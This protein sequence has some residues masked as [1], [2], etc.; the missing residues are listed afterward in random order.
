MKLRKM[1]RDCGDMKSLNDFHV[2][3]VTPDG[4]HYYCKECQNERGAKW[5]AANPDKAKEVAKRSQRKRHLSSTYG[6]SVDEYD[7]LLEKQGGVCP[8][9]Q[10]ELKR[11][12]IDHCHST[13]KIRGIL[14]RHC[15]SSLSVFENDPDAIYRLIA[16]LGITTSRGRK[17]TQ[18]SHETSSS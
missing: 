12:S 5:R 18:N 10:R 17:R 9:C 13:G 3:R 1:C 11:P 2:N 6:M 8:L 15:N 14:C 7:A 16:Y 4:R